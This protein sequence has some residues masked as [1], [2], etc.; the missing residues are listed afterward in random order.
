ME[1]M[2]KSFSIYNEHKE[3]C[4][5]YTYCRIGS[6][7]FIHFLK[8]RKRW[9]VTDSGYLGTSIKRL[10]GGGSRSCEKKISLKGHG[11]SPALVLTVGDLGRLAE[12]AYVNFCVWGSSRLLRG[13]RPPQIARNARKRT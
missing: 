7:G 1:I 11:K 5:H 12:P 2:T 6:G 4:K 13:H 3:I 8:Y 10:K 9:S